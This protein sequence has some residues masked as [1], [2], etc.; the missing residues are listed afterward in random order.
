MAFSIFRN[1]S[2]TQ[3]LEK[4]MSL[5]SKLKSSWSHNNRL[6]QKPVPASNTQKISFSIGEKDLKDERNTFKLAV[7]YLLNSQL[8][9]D[10]SNTI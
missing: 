8:L 1:H 2:G 5:K 3:I 9:G 7:H 6:K 4:E 10:T